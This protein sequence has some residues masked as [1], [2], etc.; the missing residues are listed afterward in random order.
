M[1]KRSAVRGQRINFDGIQK[2]TACYQRF[3]A[4]L[5]ALLKIAP[6]GAM[7]WTSRGRSHGFMGLHRLR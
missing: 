5:F 3:L 4:T 7:E 2:S 6:A 1:Q